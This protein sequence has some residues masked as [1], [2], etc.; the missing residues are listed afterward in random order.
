[1]HPARNLVGWVKPTGEA[2]SVGSPTLLR[3]GPIGIRLKPDR[4]GL[5]MIW[6]IRLSLVSLVAAVMGIVGFRLLPGFTFAP[7]GYL[8]VSAVSAALWICLTPLVYR[9]GLGM[10]VSVGLLSPLIGIVPFMPIALFVFLVDFRYWVVFPTGALTG[11]L[12]RAC[13]S[14]GQDSARGKPK[15]AAG[16]PDEPFA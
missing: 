12:V 4:K 6:L 7:G 13:L 11:V 15:Y 14:I 5:S 8:V 9:Q 10:A 2:V 3:P 16:L 1:V